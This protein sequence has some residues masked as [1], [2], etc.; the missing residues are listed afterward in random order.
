MDFNHPFP[1]NL[2]SIRSPDPD[3]MSKMYACSPIA[4]VDKVK[5]PVCLFVGTEDWRVPWAQGREYFNALRGLGKE[6]RMYVYEDGH[7]LA[8]VGNLVN[9]R[10][11]S[12]MFFHEIR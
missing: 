9:W 8:K 1:L 11:N 7:G 12:A 6:A 10:L 4:F 3:A 5:A 2:S